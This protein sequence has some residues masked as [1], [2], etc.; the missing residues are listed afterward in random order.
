MPGHTPKA[1]QRIEN[2]VLK[3]CQRMESTLPR[4]PV[5][6]LKTMPQAIQQSL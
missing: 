3:A 6:G 2:H 5:K 1:R 4:K